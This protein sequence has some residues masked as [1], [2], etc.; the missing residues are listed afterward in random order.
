MTAHWP[1]TPHTVLTAVLPGEEEEL[2]ADL[3]SLDR[4]P[5]PFADL[6]ST[7]FVRWVVVGQVRSRRRRP[8]RPLSTRYLLFTALSNSPVDAFLEEL[9]QRLGPELDTVWRHCVG[10]PGHRDSRA[11]VA[12]L[13]HNTLRVDQVFTAYDADVAEVRRAVRLRRAHAALAR[14]TQL[15]DDRDLQRAFLDVFG[16]D[17]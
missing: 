10:Y 3:R 17:R 5:S 14:R 15:M 13:R 7:H 9:G 11:F 2:A 16:E 4:D 8:R 12:Y 6:S 1:A